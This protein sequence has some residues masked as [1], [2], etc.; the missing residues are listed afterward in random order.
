MPPSPA[1]ASSDVAQDNPEPA[2]REGQPID[3]PP[4][5]D[6]GANRSDFGTDLVDVH[7]RLDRRVARGQQLEQGS[8]P[9]GMSRERARDD[10]VDHAG[11]ARRRGHDREMRTRCVRL[12]IREIEIQRRDH[13]R[14]DGSNHH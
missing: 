9:V 8:T 5:I 13:H 7:D 1:E 3:L 10:T 2:L 4:M 6:P 14:P 12:E 11:F